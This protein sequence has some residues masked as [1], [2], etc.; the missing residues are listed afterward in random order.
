[1]EFIGR[2]TNN[3]LVPLPDYTPEVKLKEGQ[4]YKVTAT[5]PRN[6][7]FHKK[8][9][10]LLTTVYESSSEA[11]FY[12]TFES[13]RAEVTMKSGH[14]DTHIHIDRKEIVDEETGETAF[15]T[16]GGKISYLPKSISFTN[17][18]QTEFEELFQRTIDA[19][20][21]W[22]MPANTTQEDMDNLVEIVLRFT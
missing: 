15:V 19:L 12:Q 8:Y 18:D 7:G 22:F 13:F 9:F 2:A 14:Y 21:K 1:M 10:K 11:S 5:Q 17:M 16:V 4:D 3:S 20:F 6:L